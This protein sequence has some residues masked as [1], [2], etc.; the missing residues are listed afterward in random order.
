MMDT[1]QDLAFDK[2]FD[3]KLGEALRELGVQRAA[4]VN[5]DG[6]LLARELCRRAALCRHDKTA[7]ADDAARGFLAHG[8][9]ADF[10]GN[11]AGA[12]FRGR[13]WKFTGEW[14]KSFRVTN[15]AHQNRVWQFLGT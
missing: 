14:V 7:T 3:L 9:P 10:I 5:A 11:G 1:Q 12:L 13:Q 4:T 8:L 15:H 6:L 2:G